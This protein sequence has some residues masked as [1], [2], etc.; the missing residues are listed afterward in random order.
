LARLE[1]AKAATAND[2]TIPDQQ[3]SRPGQVL[4]TVGY[5]SPEQVRGQVADARSV[6]KI[7]GCL[8]LVTR[9][10]RRNT[11]STGSS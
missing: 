11:E 6:R 2:T 5:M 3:E 7:C 1:P 9:T 4:G 8:R 10:R